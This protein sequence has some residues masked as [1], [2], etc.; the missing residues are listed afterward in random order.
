MALETLMDREYDYSWDWENRS[1]FGHKHVSPAGHLSTDSFNFKEMMGEEWYKIRKI[2][3]VRNPWSRLYDF[4]TWHFTIDRPIKRIEQKM[5]D[6]IMDKKTFDE[7]ICSLEYSKELNWWGELLNQEIMRRECDYVIR[8]EYVDEDVNRLFP[9]LKVPSSSVSHPGQW[10][11][12]DDKYIM[13]E[14]TKTIIEKFC[15]EDIDQYTYKYD[16]RIS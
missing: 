3:T 16:G 5:Y 9:G 12:D 10:Y 11:V 14:N 2:T 4:Y 8:Y 15:F 13:S 1:E 7:W 6:Y